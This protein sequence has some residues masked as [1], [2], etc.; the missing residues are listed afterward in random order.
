MRRMASSALSALRR[1][2][3]LAR[4]SPLASRCA[5]AA[6][7]L[8][9]ALPR[10]SCPVLAR[11]FAAGGS[12]G[13]EGEASLPLST[14]LKRELDHELAEYETSELVKQ[15]PPSPFELTEEPGSAVVARPCPPEAP[16]GGCLA[17]PPRAHAPP[18]AGADRYPRRGGDHGHTERA[19]GGA[20][21]RGGRLWCGRSVASFF[22]TI[23]PRGH[24][25]AR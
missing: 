20:G 10:L 3:G 14:L 6:A 5:P 15:G 1:C 25:A 21:A 18:C 24:L 22:F 17:H 13:G 2:G 8:R 23:S 12:S 9:G 11:G 19:G 7:P 4:A 16:A